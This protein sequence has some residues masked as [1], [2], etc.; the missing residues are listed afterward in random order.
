MKSGST[1][2]HSMRPYVL[3][4]VPACLCVL[5][6]AG[7]PVAAAQV[8]EAPPAERVD[9]SAPSPAVIRQR[10][11][12]IERDADASPGVVEAITEALKNRDTETRR[13]AVRTLGR[14]GRA[15]LTGLVS[16]SLADPA[17]VVRAE[18]AQALVVS[19]RAGG[20]AALATNLL[21]TQLETENHPLAKGL[22]ALALGRLRYP[23]AAT[24]QAVEQA[25]VTTTRGTQA[26]GTA[27][28]KATPAER[29]RFASPL[30]LLG[31]LRGLESFWR[32]NGGGFE[33]AS[34]TIDALRQ[35]VVAWRSAV[36]R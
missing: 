3:A 4:L 29:M 26:E 23:D 22:M 10:L 8:P 30:V 28:G 34:E 33:P 21:L 13:L 36:S 20:N 32:L 25:I 18:A 2:L 7:T 16:Q 1:L 27:S 15:N 24:A 12:S 11:L 35:L 14:L 19:V 9:E 6:L 31:A 5:W 17:P